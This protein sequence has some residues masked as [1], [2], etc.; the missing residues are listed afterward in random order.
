[1]TCEFEGPDADGFTWFRNDGADAGFELINPGKVDPQALS[2]A[3]ALWL[4]SKE[5][6]DPPGERF[7]VPEDGGTAK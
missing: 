7:V 3:M 4:A 1:M 6:D 2:E 5:T